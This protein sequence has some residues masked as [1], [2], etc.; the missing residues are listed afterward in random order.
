MVGR[1]LHRRMGDTIFVVRWSIVMSLVLCLVGV[2]LASGCGASSGDTSSGASAPTTVAGFSDSS[3]SYVYRVRSGS[4]EPTLPIGAR[5]VVKKGALAVGAIVVFHPPEGFATQQCGPEPHVVKFGGAACDAPIAR[6]A[7]IKLIKRIV[8]D[9]GDEIY[10]REGHVYR[11]ANNSGEFVRET[12][13]Y[14]R[15]CHVGSGCD[16]PVPIKIAAGHW[17]LMG[18]NRG[19]SDDSRFWGPV[20]TKWIVGVAANYVPGSPVIQ[21]QR[22][23]ERQSFHDRIIAKLEVCL[24]NAGIAVPRDDSAL[25]S[26]TSGIRT[27][28]PRVEAA[29]SR[30]QSAL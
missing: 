24:H 15:A 14:I 20:P 8:A 18:D 1:A 17:F 7:K 12:D 23:F 28:S 19:E 13:S 25:L 27:D 6:M 3:S 4:M 2:L 5:I 30:C 10:I 29:I 22:R 9:P 11:K 26:S 16:F 21:S